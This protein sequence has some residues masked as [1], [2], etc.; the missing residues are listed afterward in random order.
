MGRILTEQLKAAFPEAD[1]QVVPASDELKKQKVFFQQ[2]QRM[3]LVQNVALKDFKGK[4]SALAVEKLGALLVMKI[5]GQ[6]NLA[7]EIQEQFKEATVQLV[8]RDN[9]LFK[10]AR[11]EQK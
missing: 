11:K 9:G 1:V 4:F 8:E 3:L 10:N 6:R 2:K 7:K 5:K